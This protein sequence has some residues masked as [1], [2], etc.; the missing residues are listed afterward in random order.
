M[1]EVKGY[2]AYRFSEAVVGGLDHVITPPFDVINPAE[3]KA[4]AG[5]GPYN[6]T[7]V[8]L[9]E[10]EGG[11]GRYENAAKHFKGWIEEGALVRDE[12]ASYYVLEQRFKDKS[13][14]ARARRAILAA[15]KIP[16]EEGG[17]ILGHERT[18][19]HKIEDRL[20]LTQ[21][22][23][24]VPSPLLVMY[25]DPKAE[26]GAFLSQ[27]DEREPDLEAQTVDGVTQRL[28]KVADD[29]AV[30]RF[31][32]GKTLYIA[33]GHHRFATARAY[34]DE[35]REMNPGATDHPSSCMLF[36]LVAFDDPGLFVYPAHRILDLPE[37]F[38]FD[39]FKAQLE[40]HFDVTPVEGDLA[41][42]V[43]SSAQGAAMGMALRG[44]GCFTL[45]YKDAAG[46][47]WLGDDHGPAWRDLDVSV[48]H[49][50][51][52]EGMLGLGEDAEFLYEPDEEKAL[53]LWERGEKDAVFLLKGVT[54]QQIQACADAG[55]FMPQK[56]TYLFPKLPAGTAIY[57]L[58]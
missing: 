52:F 57:R 43:A 56:A 47:E 28:W 46:R 10:A 17:A 38:D 42:R 23:R 7:H 14:A 27:V 13:G 40:V 25:D 33:D 53:A 45:R 5:L 35:I 8:I 58:E 21:A 2:N 26:L 12:D 16:E 48:L 50:G 54:P 20:A 55:E 36:G 44:A 3:R 41:E 34:R 22:A 37:G 24:L 32:S 18:F 19:R 1:L 31:F 30:A 51:I 6:M 4:L 11:L 9:P 15:V 39:R 29:G 49:R